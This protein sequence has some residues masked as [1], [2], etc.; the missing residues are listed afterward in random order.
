MIKVAVHKT[1]KAG[2]QPINLRVN[3]SAGQGSVTCIQGPSGV[4]KTSLLKMIAGLLTPDGGSISLNNEL[5]FDADTNANLSPQKRLVGFVFQDYALFP[6]MS[7]RQHLAFATADARWIDRLLT[8]G[9][10][11]HLQNV[12]F[13]RLSG[14]QQQR[15]AILRA[16]ANKPRLLLMD[17]PFSA[18]DAQTKRQ[19][20]DD[21]KAIWQEL[22][23][24][25]MIVSHYPDELRGIAD[26]NLVV[27]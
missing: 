5:W 10:L 13:D 18:Q 16:M 26:G 6:N 11:E 9:K 14:G 2:H 27:G 24:T 20:M 25:V 15:L 3:Y 19:L 1:L 17:E 23:T 7:V 4:G 12:K 8:I 21:L 22:G